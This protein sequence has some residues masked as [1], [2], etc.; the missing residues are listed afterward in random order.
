MDHIGLDGLQ[1]SYAGYV[2]VYC[3]SFVLIHVYF[4][5]FAFCVSVV[6]LIIDC[7]FGLQELS[8][9]FG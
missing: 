5:Y 3:K 6:I 4:C 2:V 8:T 7:L 9:K 1:I